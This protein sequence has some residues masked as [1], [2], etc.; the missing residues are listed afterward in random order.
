[1]IPQRPRD[2]L[3]STECPVCPVL[4]QGLSFVSGGPIWSSDLQREVL[5]EQFVDPFT[6]RIGKRPYDEF[7]EAAR[8]VLFTDATYIVL[9]PGDPEKLTQIAEKAGSPWRNTH[10]VVDDRD[11]SITM[12]LVTEEIM[13]L[14]RGQAVPAIMEYDGANHIVDFGRR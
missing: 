2:N 11:L 13:R 14:D 12:K 4:L 10:F 1:M 8:L 3:Q 7:Q 6:F 9:C 5:T